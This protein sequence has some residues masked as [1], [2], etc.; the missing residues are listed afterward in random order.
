MQY[1]VSCSLIA[2]L[3][4]APRAWACI[5]ED[6]ERATEVAFNNNEV[7]DLSKLT[8]I[9]EA[10]VNYRLEDRESEYPVVAYRSHFDDRAM[11]KVGYGP[12]EYDWR[13]VLIVLPEDM[14]PKTF[15]FAL[16]MRQELAWLVQRGAIAGLDEGEIPEI[17][18][19]LAP[20]VR[21]FTREKVL[22]YQ[23]CYAPDSCVDCGGPAAYTQLPPEPL[24]AETGVGWRM[25]GSIKALF[26]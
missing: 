19:D 17:T 18:Q 10:D 24:G 12:P 13:S 9:G 6:A 22:S 21:F 25:W 23:S 2:A 14:D 11:V 7:F 3:I 16:A 4:A 26:R 5:P 8:G 1:I 20:E 15:D